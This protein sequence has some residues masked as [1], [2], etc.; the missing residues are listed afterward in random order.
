MNLAYKHFIHVGAFQ[1]VEQT[2]CQ[3]EEMLVEAGL[4]PYTAPHQR[5]NS[6]L[7]HPSLN[8]NSSEVPLIKAL[9]LAG[10]H[11]NL[12]VSLTGRVNRTPGESTA[13]VHPSSINYPGRGR[14]S[15]GED[16]MAMP[17]GTLLT[18]S[19]MNRSADGKSIFLR[20]TSRT[21]PLMAALFGGR[22]RSSPN[23]RNVLVMDDWLPL[24][25]RDTDDG[26]ALKTV[27]ELRKALDRMLAGAFRD[28]SRR[29]DSQR[30]YLADVEARGVFAQGLVEVRWPAQHPSSL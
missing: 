5:Q 22:L 6:E 12:A 8:E 24:Y 7:G 9:A 20:E 15:S 29:G 16:D 30:G 10:M 13:M 18:Y 14:G 4:I 1:T 17:R 19:T 11:P 25:V 28:L 23:S 26:R 21:S 3:I 27:V 2:A